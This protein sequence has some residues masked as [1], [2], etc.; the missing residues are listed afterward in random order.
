VFIDGISAVKGITL[1]GGLVI[2]IDAMDELAINWCKARGLTLPHGVL[3]SD[4]D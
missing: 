4:A 2:D 1:N 3:E